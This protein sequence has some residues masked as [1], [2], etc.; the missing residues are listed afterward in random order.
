M[1]H[2]KCPI[3]RDPLAFKDL[4]RIIIVKG[5]DGMPICPVLLSHHTNTRAR[6][7]M[8][9]QTCNTRSTLTRAPCAQTKR[10][11]IDFLLYI[12][13][14][15]LLNLSDSLKA[16]QNLTNLLTI[17]ITRRTLDP[18]SNVICIRTSGRVYSTQMLENF[19]F[20]EEDDD[21]NRD[22]ISNEPVHQADVITIQD[23]FRL[24]QKQQLARDRAKKFDAAEMFSHS[25]LPQA[26]AAREI[27]NVENY[28]E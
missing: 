5:K 22:P 12:I 17:K 2:G 13:L 19:D 23:P 9:T 11:Y 15:L 1:K 7:Y 10:K 26:P 6:P 14:M 20:G 16:F 8:H 28:V 21:D 24:A 18:N 25:G 27:F 4:T 3:T